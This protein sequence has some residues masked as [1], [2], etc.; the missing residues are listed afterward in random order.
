[1]LVALGGNAI[2]QR[3]QRG[4]YVEQMENVAMAAGSIADLVE[5]GCRVVLTHGN[6]PQVGSILLQNEEAA[7]LT[8]AM[9]LVA[10]VA[11]TQGL[12]AFMLQMSLDHALE[13]RGLTQ[14]CSP[15]ITPVVVDLGDPAFARPTK[16]IGP[17]YTRARAARL[18]SQRGL[19]MSED[20][21]RGW[22]RVV[23]SPRPLEVVG[24]GAV[25]AVLNAGYIPVACGGGGIPVTR[26]DGRLVGVDA[27]I[28]KDLA[29]ATLADQ[30]NANILLILTDVPHVMLN[31]GR[32]NETPVRLMTVSQARSHALE[33]QF[34]SGSM[35]PKVEAACQFVESGA[36][37]RAV[38]APLGRALEALRGE[39][40][41]EISGARGQPVEETR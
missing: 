10:C 37:R 21:G 31:H 3:G 1:M 41:T 24:I 15:M 40:G 36:G 30:L 20:A 38:I 39:V 35:G 11:K 12:I 25:K 6:G 16:P 4:A 34:A 19:T 23:A 33:G 22:R 7:P 5:T 18:A 14:R 26:A 8:P 27:V 28:D 2:L 9:P 29:A 17:F 13:Q 32:E